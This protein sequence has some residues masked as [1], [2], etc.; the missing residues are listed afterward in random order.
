MD[1]GPQVPL[2]PQGHKDGVPQAP[3]GLLAHPVPLVI[4][5]H[6]VPVV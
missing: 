1:L 4:M 3:Q 2:G 6:L 5:A